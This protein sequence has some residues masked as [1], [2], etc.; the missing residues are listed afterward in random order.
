MAKTV[1]LYYPCDTCSCTSEDNEIPHSYCDLCD[2]IGCKECVEEHF[3]M[4]HE[5]DDLEYELEDEDFNDE[6]A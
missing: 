1:N 4:K 6:S 3:F 2:F 5:D